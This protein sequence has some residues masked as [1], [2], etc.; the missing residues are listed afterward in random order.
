LLS[1]LPLVG[2]HHQLIVAFYINKYC[3]DL[4]SLQV[5]FVTTD[6]LLL[7][8]LPPLAFAAFVAAGCLVP[9]ANCCF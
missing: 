7:H 5:A 2:W 4:S 6:E 3:F 8:L 9:L 1:L